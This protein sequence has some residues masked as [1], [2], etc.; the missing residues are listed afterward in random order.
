MSLKTPLGQVRG[1]G[2]AR[3]GTHH[4]WMQRVTAVALVPLTLWF[5]YSMVG[6]AG[7]GH[8]EM[9][10]W[11]AS[12]FNAIMMV[13][14]IGAT[15]HHLQLGLQVVV[16]D[17]IH[18]EAAKVAVMLVVKL[19]SVALAVAAVFAVLKVAFTA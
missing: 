19:A 14:L 2:S 18:S 10:R 3:S 12:P 15:F 4:W 6:H 5:I 17:Y 13:L 9:A 1:L 16:E 8:G 7:A 11:L